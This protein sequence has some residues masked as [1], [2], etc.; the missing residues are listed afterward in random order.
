MQEAMAI[1]SPYAN[2]CEGSNC[3]KPP[4]VPVA[5]YFLVQSEKMCDPLFISINERISQNF[6]GDDK[7]KC[8]SSTITAGK[9]LFKLLPS[10]QFAIWIIQLISYFEIDL[11]L[12]LTSF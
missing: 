1:C 6:S 11:K 7:K 8:D 3:I 5:W 9:E 10:F 12:S 2:D 4:A